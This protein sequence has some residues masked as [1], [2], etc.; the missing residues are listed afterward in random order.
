MVLFQLANSFKALVFFMVLNMFFS[1]N[2]YAFSYQLNPLENKYP[3]IL[4]PQEILY[5]ESELEF[6]ALQIIT[7]DFKN[8]IGVVKRLLYQEVGFLKAL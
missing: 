6:K 2:G 3:I 4:T 8:E 5:R 1:F 7:S